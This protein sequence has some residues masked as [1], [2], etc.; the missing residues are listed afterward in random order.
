VNI[1]GPSTNGTDTD[2]VSIVVEP[3]LG[4]FVY[5]A[6]RLGDSISGFK[7]D[8]D[9]GALSATQATPYPIN[10]AYPAAVIAVPHGNHATQS[11]A[12]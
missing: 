12:P 9:T 4:R 11:V 2:P 10:G 8:P 5:T 6:N 7:L 1:S 3:S